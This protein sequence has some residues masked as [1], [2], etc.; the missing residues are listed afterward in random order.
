RLNVTDSYLQRASTTIIV[1]KSEDHQIPVVMI[2]G[3]IHKRVKRRDGFFIDAKATF[4]PCV[5]TDIKRLHFTWFS[6]PPLNLTAS[7]SLRLFVPPYL[8]QTEIEYKFTLKTAVIDI[9]N[10]EE[11][12]SSTIEAFATAVSSN[13]IAK[14]SGGSSRTVPAF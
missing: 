5:S 11:I 6:D 2:E 13:L 8:L 1:E 14:I 4:S 12:A 3:S 7:N 9:N 10:E